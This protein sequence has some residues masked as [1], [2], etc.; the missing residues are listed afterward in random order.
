MS[1]ISCSRRPHQA[2]I[3]RTLDRALRHRSPRPAGRGRVGGYPDQRFGRVLGRKVELLVRDDK[4]KPD[5]AARRA[6]ELIES[7]R[8]ELMAASF[9]PHAKWLSMSSA[10]SGAYRIS[11]HIVA[12]LHRELVALRRLEREERVVQVR[13]IHDVVG[14]PC[15]PATRWA[16]FRT[17]RSDYCARGRSR[18]HR[19]RH[20]VPDGVQFVWFSDRSKG[21]RSNGVRRVPK[22]MHVARWRL[23]C[24]HPLPLVVLPR[25]IRQKAR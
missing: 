21:Q 3:S 24:S 12:M 25:V 4:L 10:S 15:I 5:E 18:D 13:V 9:R 11:R 2:R 7:E 22:D 23:P 17:C 14:R 1:S 16:S 19:R 20:R 8:V 6:K